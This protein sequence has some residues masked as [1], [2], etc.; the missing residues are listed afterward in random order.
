MTGAA[1]GEDA[2]DIAGRD[3]PDL[4]LLDMRMPGMSGIEAGRR[5]RYRPFSPDG[6]DGCDAHGRIGDE[7]RDREAV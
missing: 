6:A 7:A 4:A 2:L 5:L 3:A 1:S